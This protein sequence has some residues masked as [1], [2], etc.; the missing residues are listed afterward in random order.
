MHR[1]LLQTASPTR[2]MTASSV[3]GSQPTSGGTPAAVQCCDPV[4]QLRSCRGELPCRRVGGTEGEE[5]GER[6]GAE[7][8]VP[9]VPLIALLLNQVKSLDWLDGLSDLHAGIATEYQTQQKRRTTKKK[10]KKERRGRTRGGPRAPD[11]APRSERK[12]GPFTD[13]GQQRGKQDLYYSLI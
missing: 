6:G 2:E 5:G 3:S 7:G 8:H 4:R 1:V 9:M 10:K 11:T 13:A 12:R